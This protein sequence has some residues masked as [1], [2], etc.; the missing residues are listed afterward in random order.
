MGLNAPG[1]SEGVL[2]PRRTNGRVRSRDPDGPTHVP[3]VAC[4]SNASLAGRRPDGRRNRG[5]SGGQPRESG[6]LSD[7]KMPDNTLYDNDLQDMTEPSA[8]FP[9]LQ[10]VGRFSSSPSAC[11]VCVDTIS[12]TMS[13]G[14]ALVQ[15]KVSQKK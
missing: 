13:R 12:D 15:E 5:Q 6:F 3:V 1:V 14:I 11:R 8:G 7:P 4:C 9:T 2:S 10:N